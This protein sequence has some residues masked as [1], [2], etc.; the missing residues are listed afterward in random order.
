MP[1]LCRFAPRAHLSLLFYLP[2]VH[3][4][5]A[6][7]SCSARVVSRSDP[8]PSVLISALPIRSPPATPSYPLSH[9]HFSCSSVRRATQYSTRPASSRFKLSSLIFPLPPPA[10]PI[11][12]CCRSNY[13]LRS[14]RSVSI[15][16]LRD[17]C[18]D[19]LTLRPPPPPH[20]PARLQRHQDGGGV[21]G[22]QR[23]RGRGVLHEGARPH[24]P[25]P[26][27]CVPPS[28]SPPH[29][30]ARATDG[31]LAQLCRTISS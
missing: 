21:R 27:R 25:A 6:C 8:L 9:H 16:P 13:A 14:G 3:S 29:S 2:G 11:S 1:R 23:R 30:A 17:P 24:R 26:R 19:T 31:Q 4:T 10:S 22:V 7:S 18:I 20:S 12:A 15:S 28:P 5:L